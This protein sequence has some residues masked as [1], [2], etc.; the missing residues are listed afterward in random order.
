MTITTCDC[1]EE[2]GSHSPSISMAL[3][4]KVGFIS[5]LSAQGNK[6]NVVLLVFRKVYTLILVWRIG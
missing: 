4:N 1:P 6:F 3:I 2:Y 5:I